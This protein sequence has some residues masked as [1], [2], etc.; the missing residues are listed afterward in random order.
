MLME[1]SLLPRV[2]WYLFGALNTWTR[3]PSPSTPLFG[4]GGG[5]DDDGGHYNSPPAS[6][7]IASASVVSHISDAG[8]G[9]LEIRYRLVS[10]DEE[11]EEF[12]DD[13]Y[14]PTG[15]GYFSVNVINNHIYTFN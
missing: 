14:S 4:G 9:S 12:D 13:D 8:V 6:A 3:L 11:E 10:A 5:S 15:D 1:F 7:A 2:I